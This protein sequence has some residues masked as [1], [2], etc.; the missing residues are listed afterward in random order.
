MPCTAASAGQQ[1]C[2][3]LIIVIFFLRACVCVFGWVM[4]AWLGGFQTA[5]N[6]GQALLH[7]LYRLPSLC[8]TWL[9]EVHMRASGC[10]LAWLGDASVRSLVQPGHDDLCCSCA[11]VA[12]QA[13]GS[14]HW[15]LPV[16][17]GSWQLVWRQCIKCLVSGAALQLQCCCCT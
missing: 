13:G 9:P 15:L 3:H 11:A 17:E 1:H 12:C 7:F 10:L 14:Q 6:H 4:D 2:V 16:Q 5:R 8:F